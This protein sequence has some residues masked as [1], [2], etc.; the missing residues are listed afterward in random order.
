MTSCRYTWSQVPGPCHCGKATAIRAKHIEH[1]QM[2]VND[3]KL[4]PA[5]KVVIFSDRKTWTIDPVR[6]KGNDRYLSLGEEDE[7]ARTLSKT[8][9][10]AYVISL[11]FVAFNG[12]V[13]PLIWLHSGYQPNRML[14]F[15]QAQNFSI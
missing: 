5:G 2:L 15:L 4:A 9:H 3:L 6:N 14:H 12:A 13:M 11:G 1:C 10:P 8:K 7:S